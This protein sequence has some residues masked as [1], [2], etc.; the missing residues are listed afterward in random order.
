MHPGHAVL[1]YASSKYSRKMLSWKIPWLTLS[2]LL[3]I[4]YF[5]TDFLRFVHVQSPSGCTVKC[6]LVNM[7]PSNISPILYFPGKGL[8]IVLFPPY[9]HLRYRDE[10]K[11]QSSSAP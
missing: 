4:L 8:L 1:L 7:S 3:L 11:K 2:V 9:D 6:K 10:D 5:C